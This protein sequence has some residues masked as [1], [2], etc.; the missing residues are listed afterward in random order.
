M[1]FWFSEIKTPRCASRC[2]YSEKRLFHLRLH[3]LSFI[4]SKFSSPFI[5]AKTPLIAIKTFQARKM[6]ASRQVCFPFIAGIF[7]LCSSLV[8]LIKKLSKNR[9]AFFW[10][11]KMFRSFNK[12]KSRSF[13][14]CA[15]YGAIASVWLFSLPAF[16]ATN[17][18]LTSESVFDSTLSGDASGEVVFTLAPGATVAFS[19]SH[20]IPANKMVSIS[21][22]GGVQGVGGG[23]LSLASFLDI[24]ATS[25]FSLQGVNVT[26]SRS[27]SQ[28]MIQAEGDFSGTISNSSLSGNL[29]GNVVHAGAMVVGGDFSGTIAS[30]S[31]SNNSAG[32]GWGAGGGALYIEGNFTGKITGSD[33]AK[34]LFS[35]NSVNGSQAGGG[36]IFVNHGGFS[37]ASVIEYAEFS[38]NV[39]S[40]WGGAIETYGGVGAISDGF[41]AT[42]SHDRFV[43]N[44]SVLSGGAIAVYGGSFTGNIEHSLFQSNKATDSSQGVGGAIAADFGFSGTISDTQFIQNSAGDVGG[45]LAVYNGS[46]TGSIADSEFRGN[47]ALSASSGDGGAIYIGDNLR[48]KKSFS[49][50]LSNTVFESNVAGES[51]GAIAF[52]NGGFTDDASV[53]STTFSKN[54][55]RLYGGAIALEGTNVAV[56]AGGFFAGTWSDDV[57]ES[58]SAEYGGAIYVNAGDFSANLSRATFSGNGSSSASANYYGGAIYIGNGD[59]SGTISGQSSF[60][61]NSSWYGGAIALYNGAFLGSVSDTLF[62]GNGTTS[63][64]T[65]YY[66]GAIYLYSGSSFSG[67]LIRDDFESNDV[68]YYGGAIDIEGD[69][70]GLIQDSVFNKNQATDTTYGYGGALYVGGKTTAVIE[71]ATFS[72]NSAGLYGG[73]LFLN[74]GFSGSISQNSSFTGNQSAIGGAIFTN[75]NFSGSVDSATFSANKATAGSGSA[76][77]VNGDLTGALTNT[78]F[79]GNIAEGGRGAIFVSGT[80]NSDLSGSSFTNNKSSGGSEGGAIVILKTGALTAMTGDLS[81]RGNLQADGSANAIAVENSLNQGDTFSL[82][83]GKARK[84]TFDDPIESSSSNTKLAVAI[85]PKEDESGTVL[86]TGGQSNLYFDA[87]ATVSHGAMALENGAVFGANSNSGAF[88]LGKDAALDVASGARSTPVGI[89]ASGGLTLSG[90]LNFTMPDGVSN[91]DTMMTTTGAVTL[92]SPVVTLAFAAS[93]NLEAGNHVNLIDA[94]TNLVQGDVAASSQKVE[95]KVG[96]FLTYDFT[97]EKSADNHQLIALL[98]KKDDVTPPPCTGDGCSGGG[99]PQPQPKP[100]PQPQPQPQPKPQPSHVDPGIQSLADGYLAGFAALSEGANLISENGVERMLNAAQNDQ[101]WHAFGVAG[102][103]REKTDEGRLRWNGVNLMAGVARHAMEASGASATLGVFGEYG[104]V[105]SETTGKAVKGSGKAEFAGAGLLGRWDFAGNA[106]GHPYLEAMLH[107][108]RVSTDFSNN[109]ASEGYLDKAGFDGASSGYGGA[110]AG[111]GYVWQ[112]SAK[113]LFNFY[114][115]Y[116][117][118]REGCVTHGMLASGEKVHFNAIS[119]SLVKLGW[120]YTYSYSTTAHLYAGL[121]YE[122]QSGGRAEGFAHSDFANGEARIESKSLRGSTGVEEIGFTWTQVDGKP[123]TLELGET[124]SV[125]ERKGVGGVFRVDWAF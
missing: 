37:S 93:A 27:A 16:G 105:D 83:A 49:G 19:S 20:S 48:D 70:S 122:Y 14:R 92:D 108:G 100:Q 99:T 124:G 31:F 87:G 45:A 81:F 88:T 77:Y 8:W 118:M 38:N 43:G 73:A 82:G 2:S 34:S 1:K 50:S 125:G 35:G 30:S 94:G 29:G 28:A 113:Q 112:A 21:G 78:S 25:L 91:D 54:S 95:A 26:G 47:Q 106:S 64:G 119:S 116:F 41:G 84:M 90:T 6:R 11:R 10:R 89:D 114:A 109:H 53:D 71:G 61:G 120:R 42:L 115:K 23:T 24:P 3:T 52:R 17:A 104:R 46:F 111:G 75:G 22:G 79:S 40:G 15:L 5:K 69:F 72:N 97:V 110:M 67:K 63:L 103:G 36:A 57:F 56:R 13:K 80:M 33:N 9:G 101:K 4:L 44:T 59:F 51:G 60:T 68:S 117:W 85:N 62:S 18:D 12:K 76:L 66:G 65:G 98:D 102:G 7:L 96:S 121:G 86:F 74:S 55:A 32:S 58:N 107:G 123:V 39:S